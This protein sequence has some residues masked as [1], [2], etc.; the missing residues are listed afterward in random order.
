MKA[1]VRHIFLGAN[2]YKVTLPF[3]ISSEAE[4]YIAGVLGNP[5]PGDWEAA[6]IW[7][8]RYTID[9]QEIGEAFTL[10]FYPPDTR[11]AA[12]FFDL[13]GRSISIQPT[14]LQKLVGKTLVVQSREITRK[15]KKDVIRVL[16]SVGAD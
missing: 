2:D 6:L 16:G 1:V 5:P 9:D 14:S 4:A 3:A 10:G 7:C 12:S 11:P 13:C 15:G 8:S